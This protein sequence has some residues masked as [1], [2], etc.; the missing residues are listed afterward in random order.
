VLLT[1]KP[2]LKVPDMDK[3]FLVCT[4]AS[5]EGLGRVLMQDGQVITYIFGKLR[6][7]EENYEMHD[8][9]LLSIVHALRV[10]IHY[11]IGQKFELK[12]D[13]CRLQ[14]IFTQSELN[15]QQQH[16]S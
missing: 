8:L 2:I 6:R 7:H 14:Q 10:W 16:W 13:H 4:D 12:T 11:L 5:K 3:D 15:T 1:T 9:E